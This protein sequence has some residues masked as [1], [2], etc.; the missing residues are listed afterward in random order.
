M[1]EN[2]IVPVVFAN[3]TV[4][5]LTVLLKVKPPVFVTNIVPISVPTMPLTVTAPLV[6]IVRW[7]SALSAVPLTAARDIGVPALLPTVNVTL[8]DIVTAPM[9]IWPVEVSPTRDV[10]VTATGTAPR[11]M[12]PI[13]EAL[14]RPKRFIALCVIA[15]RPPVK[16]NESVALL[17]PSV[18]DPVFKNVVVPAMVLSA[19][20]NDTAYAAVPAFTVIP[21]VKVTS[22]AKVIASAVQSV[23]INVFPDTASKK[24]TPA[25]SVILIVSMSVPMASATVTAPPV[26]IVRL[27]LPEPPEP[28]TLS[29]SIAAAVPPLA[30]TVSVTP[31]L[32]VESPRLIVP[33]AEPPTVASAVTATSV[34]KSPSVIVEVPEFDAI[35]PAIFISLWAV[36][37]I[38][39]PVA[40]KVSEDPLPRVNAPVLLNVAAATLLAPPVIDKL[41]ASVPIFAV[42]A[43]VRIK[44]P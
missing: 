17:V 24:S 7:E 21:V 3:V 23:I 41:Y 13:P 31:A 1:S 35:V 34:L 27:Q 19:P 43:P 5:A 11:L 44:L 33:V 9:V 40:V 20:S 29:S 15:V 10:P 32:S 4:T 25:E 18:N 2:V 12:T 8:S 30:P 36:A 28:V 6:F 14:T 16:V 37:V 42:N 26:F 38:A 39:P 22:P